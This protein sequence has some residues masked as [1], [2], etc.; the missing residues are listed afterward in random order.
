MSKTKNVKFLKNVN[1]RN[2]QELPEFL[3]HIFFI[4]HELPEKEYLIYLKFYFN[5]F[6]V[7][8]NYYKELNQFP[9]NFPNSLCSTK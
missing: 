4:F 3:R 2:P 8:K 7:I 5:I 6:I 1:Q 9:E